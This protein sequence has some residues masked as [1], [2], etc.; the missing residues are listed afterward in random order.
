MDD[1]TLDCQL[2][3]S[4][5][6]FETNSN[7][8][9]ETFCGVDDQFVPKVGMTFNTLED[10]AKFYKDYSKVAVADE[11][12]LSVIKTTRQVLVANHWTIPL[13]FIPN[14]SYPQHNHNSHPTPSLVYIHGASSY[15]TFTVSGHTY[16]IGSAEHRVFTWRTWWLATTFTQGNSYL[17]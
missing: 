10:A 11:S 7:E 14:S 5:V 13:S 8:V 16:D 9:P 2:N 6:D 3:Q 1:S 15:K 17:R 4:K 12:H